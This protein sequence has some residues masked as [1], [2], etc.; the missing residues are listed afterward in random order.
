MKAEP[1]HYAVYGGALR[2]GDQIEV[3]GD[4]VTILTVDAPGYAYLGGDR[5]RVFVSMETAGR[6]ELE[7]KAS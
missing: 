5:P 1:T 4:W 3:D 7:R 2:P 6:R